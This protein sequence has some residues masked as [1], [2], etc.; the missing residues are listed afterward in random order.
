[1]LLFLIYLNNLEQLLKY[2]SNAD[3]ANINIDQHTVTKV[4]KSN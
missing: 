1:M 2:T 4:H 3:D